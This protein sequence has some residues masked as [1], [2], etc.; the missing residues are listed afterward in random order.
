MEKNKIQILARIF[1]PARIILRQQ[2]WV[3][4]MG[5]LYYIIL[6]TPRGDDRRPPV[7]WIVVSGPTSFGT[8]ER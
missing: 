1:A 6:K 5:P 8:K 2:K 4:P 3:G 7:L